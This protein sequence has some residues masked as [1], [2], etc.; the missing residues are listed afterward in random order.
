MEIPDVQNEI[1]L[2]NIDPVTVAPD[3]QPIT[4]QMQQV[5]TELK[6]SK[7]KIKI[8]FAV[9]A[10]ILILAYLGI[11]VYLKYYKFY[12]SDSKYGFVIEDQKGWYSVSQKEGVYYSIGT[13][14]TQKGEV[15]SYFGVSPINHSE[16][17]LLLNIE[18]FKKTCIENA[19]ETKTTFIDAGNV[20]VNNLQG[21]TCI[22]EGKVTNLDKIY[23]IKQFYLFNN[24]GGN[25]D[26]ILSASFPKGNGVEEGK[27][28]KIINNFYAK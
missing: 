26:Y 8:I 3:P 24:S 6:K 27:V 21:F 28:T 22:S 19:L 2:P 18:T 23:T 5:P 20:T 25:Y 12:Y 16:N 1:P 7:P 10:T 15:I 13:S 4:T 14:D 9:L 11:W 17:N